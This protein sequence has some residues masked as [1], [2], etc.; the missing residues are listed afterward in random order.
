MST[1]PF[2]ILYQDEHIVAIDKPAGVFVHKTKMAERGARYV[3]QELR[4]QLGKMVNPIHRLDRPTSGVLLFAFASK[5]TRALSEALAAGEI[6]KEYLAIVRGYMDDEGVIDYALNREDRPDDL[7]RQ[8]AVTH[9]LCLAKVELDV[10]VTKYPTSRYSLV[11][12]KPQTGRRHQLRRHLAHVFHPIIGDTTHGE[13]K[14]NRFF[15]QEYGVNRLLLFAQSLAF[16]HPISGE[17]MKVEAPLP[18]D[19]CR[20]YEKF[21]WQK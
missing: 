8:E 14:H 21:G 10:A 12:L 20:L 16:T 3:L 13:G 2:H 1:S 15:R 9:Y 7:K 18:E 6:E 4:D 19:F 17:R 11:H 5:T